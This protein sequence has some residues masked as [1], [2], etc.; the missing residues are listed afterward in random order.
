M[1]KI[2]N[3][4]LK[5]EN[6]FQFFKIL[7]FDSERSEKRRCECKAAVRQSVSNFGIRASGFKSGMTLIEVLL[8]VVLLGTGG[9]ALLLATARCLEVAGRSKHYSTAQR[10]IANISAEHPLSRGM[11]KE[12]RDSGLFYDAPGYR[13]EREIEG[14]DTEDREGL[15]T[16]RTR[17]L[18]SDRGKSAYEEIVTWVFIPPEED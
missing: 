7:N 3:L 10:L 1:K 5:A 18:W 15:F 13:W 17:V 14:A 9:G 8:A 11:I 16:V 12:G 2:K 4:K 6:R